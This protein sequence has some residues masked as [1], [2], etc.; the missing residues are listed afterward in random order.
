MDDATNVIV[1]R[2]EFQSQLAALINEFSKDSECNTQDFVLAMYLDDCLRS[3]GR[4]TARREQLLQDDV[5][6]EF[7]LREPLKG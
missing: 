7:D 6:S 1:H 4:A 3:F 5:K 2:S